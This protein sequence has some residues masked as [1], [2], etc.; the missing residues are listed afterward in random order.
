MFLSLGLQVQE[1]HQLESNLQVCQF[2]ADTR[3]FM[4]QMIRTINIK[5]EVLITMQIVGDLSYAW[6]IIDRCQVADENI[7]AYLE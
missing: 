4:H 6:Q 3:K 1:F 7:L 2:L 5:E